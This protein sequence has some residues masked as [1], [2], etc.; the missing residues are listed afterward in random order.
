LKFAINRSS[1]IPYYV[2]V[3]DALRDWIKQGK[4][5]T[6]DQLPGEHELCTTFDVSRPVIRQALRELTSEGLIRREKGKGTFVSGPKIKE[7]LVQR[8][9]GF[10]QDMVAQGYTPVT[11][12][13]KQE[14]IAASADIAGYLKLAVGDSVIKIE[15]LRFIEDEP[16]V[17]VTTYVPLHLCPALQH[18][19][20]SHQS[21]YTFLEQS[22][23]ITIT[24]GHRMVEAVPASKYVS[25]LLKIRKGSPLILLDSVSYMTDGTPV[26]YY[27]AFHRG[28]RSQFEVELVRVPDG[29]SVQEVL[30]NRPS[31]S[32][33][34]IKPAKPPNR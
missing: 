4:W 34:L 14:V 18:E 16:I 21:L 2:Q 22:C 15:R 8:L 31:L 3:K 32:P 5:K 19:D 1:P 20:L 6:G 17:L 24:Y 26:E 30:S 7:G 25:D 13:L 9:T 11:K 28:D 10:Y 27:Y 29:T 23:H 33:R 12:V